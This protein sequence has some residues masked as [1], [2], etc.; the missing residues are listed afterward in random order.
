MFTALAELFSDEKGGKGKESSLEN[1][2]DFDSTDKI[3][4]AN[5]LLNVSDI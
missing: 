4:H 3:L 2:Q 5:K 1:T